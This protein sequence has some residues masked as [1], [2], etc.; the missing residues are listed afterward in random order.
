MSSAEALANLEKRI[1]EVEK[2]QGAINQQVPISG[3]VDAEEK[4]ETLMQLL[5]ADR[6]EAEE[7][8]SDRE[9]LKEEN[10]TLRTQLEKCQYRIKHLLRTLE[11]H[12]N[13]NKK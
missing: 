7:V 2:R 11:R 6:S 1:A 12:D 4:L 8:L 5:Q 13:S 3:D 10:E 9:R